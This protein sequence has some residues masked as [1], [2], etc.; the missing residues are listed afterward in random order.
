MMSA[1]EYVCQQH[2]SV[3]A[4]GAATV[5]SSKVVHTEGGA[6]E[7]QDSAPA[8]CW[9]AASRWPGMPLSLW[10]GEA[11]APP[12][13]LERQLSPCSPPSPLG[14]E[15][16]ALAETLPPLPESMV[17]RV[18]YVCCDGAESFKRAKSVP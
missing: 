8:A 14:C 15:E 16:Q 13:L 3:P 2:P 9:E 5:A 10:P 11:R 17:P 18:R 6:G 7:G 4:A 12:L 1:M